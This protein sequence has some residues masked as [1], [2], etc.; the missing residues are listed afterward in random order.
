M[1]SMP[2]N[3]PIPIPIAIVDARDNQAEKVEGDGE[4]APV[5]EPDASVAGEV[6]NTNAVIDGDVASNR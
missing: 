6:F 2:A 4:S 3:V 5:A 1:L